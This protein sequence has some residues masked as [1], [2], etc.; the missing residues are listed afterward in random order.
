MKH[1]IVAVST[2]LV[3]ATALVA[4]SQR[5]S[6]AEKRAPKSAP[7]T[8]TGCLRA[9]GDH[10]RLT[11]LHGENA[12]KSRSWKRGYLKKSTRDYEVISTASGVKLKDHVNHQVTLTGTA[13][14]GWQ[15][16]ARSL[17]HVSPS[18]S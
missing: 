15:L 8:L 3:L 12:P 10:Y 18:C 2:A 9:D 6:A 17:K 7:V 1:T 16:K 11:D 14:S 4:T 13:E 5:V